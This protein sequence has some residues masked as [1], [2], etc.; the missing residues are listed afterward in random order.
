VKYIE[1]EGEEA[2]TPYIDGKFFKLKGLVMLSDVRLKKPVGIIEELYAGWDNFLKD[3]IY[4]QLGFAGYWDEY[5]GREVYRD[6]E[7]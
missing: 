1:G 6:M 4:K 7:I 5:L 2:G 3:N